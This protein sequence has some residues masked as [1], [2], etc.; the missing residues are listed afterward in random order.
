MKPSALDADGGGKTSGSQFLSGGEQ[1]GRHDW[2]GGRED[3]TA[4]KHLVSFRWKGWRVSGRTKQRLK[5]PAR[6]TSSNYSET[7]RGRTHGK[8]KWFYLLEG[9]GSAQRKS[10]GKPAEHYRLFRG[11]GCDESH[12]GER[13]DSL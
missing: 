3:V 5:N 7:G 2:K 11:E 6:R 9:Q 4:H 12:G 13:K 8:G 10:W 1:R